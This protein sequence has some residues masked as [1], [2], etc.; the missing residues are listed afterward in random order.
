[1]KLNY[2]RTL[3][4]GFAFFLICAF[5]QAYDAIVPL[6]LTNKF[7]LSQGASGIIMSLDN[8]LA[9]F[10]LP[11]FGALSDK[12]RSRFGKRTPFILIGTICAIVCFVS[13]T[14]VDQAQL[15]K[16]KADKQ[17]LWNYANTMTVENK[18]NDSVIDAS[19]ETS[20]VLRDY[21]ARLFYNTDYDSLTADKQAELAQKY[22]NLGYDSVYT[23]DKE[24]KTYAAYDSKADVPDGLRS[25]NTYVALVSSAENLFAHN[26]T[27]T[28]PWTLVLFIVL[29]LMTL[30]SMAVFRSPAVALMPDV[31]VKPLRSKA[32]AIINLMGTA[33]GILV[34]LLGMVFGT[35]KVQNQMMPYTWYVAAVCG[36]MAVALAVFILTVREPAWNAQM[37][38]TQAKLDEDNPEERDETVVEV[39]DQ[40]NLN[41][42]ADV[43]Q[44]KSASNKLSKDK[45]T[46]LILILASVALWFIGYNAI[47]SKYSVYA[48][49]ELNKDYNTTLLIAQAAAVVAYIP[50]GMIASKLG[51]KRTILIGIALLTAAFFGAI[52]VTASSPTWLLIV[53]FA[54]AGIAWATIN[55]NSFPM[56]VEL[57]KGST[58]GKYTGYYYTASMA[59]QIVTPIL[60][61]YL[62]QAFGTMRILFPYGTIF[63]A[64]SFVTMLFVKHGDSKP[65]KPK[66]KMEMLAGADD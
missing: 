37:L 34:L 23:Y 35:G 53:L 60:S 4:V 52:F 22:A 49:N 46:S 20:I 7:G 43:P 1:M 38:E 45:L 47:T 26:V 59:A 21:A 63:V 50:V 48:V 56:V 6:M 62:M 27:A 18:E 58:I 24:T 64:L 11:L 10:M 51:R 13:L 2:K 17:A 33:G 44:S 8:I 15:N 31:T 41:E 14:F 55:V 16:V 9:L 3:L 30:I 32:N 40:E 5:W 36:I 54:L 28:S 65:D 25:K 12:S 42:V 66:D 19:A 57:A 61:G 29:L 39:A